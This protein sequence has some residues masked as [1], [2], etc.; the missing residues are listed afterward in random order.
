MTTINS[1]IVGTKFHPAGANA[2]SDAAQGERVALVREPDN[3]FDPNA[4]AVH[5]NDHIR[6]SLGGSQELVAACHEIGV[7]LGQAVL[8]RV[9]VGRGEVVAQ[10]ARF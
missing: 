6:R 5:I 8:E 7:V 1:A 9:G 3:E 2:L 4:V 10:A